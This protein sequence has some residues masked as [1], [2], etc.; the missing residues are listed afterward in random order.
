MNARM[1]LLLLAGGLSLGYPFSAGP[2][3]R[4]EAPSPPPSLETAKDLPPSSEAHAPA[5]SCP[6]PKNRVAELDAAFLFWWSKSTPTVPFATT[7]API[8]AGVLGAPTTAVVLGGGGGLDYNTQ[9]GA[10]FAGRFLVNEG[11][12]AAVGGFF[13]DNKDRERGALGLSTLAVPF[14]DATTGANASI[15]LAD[16]NAS[17]GAAT[18]RITNL[19][20]GLDASGFAR[21][22]MA[23]GI[24]LDVLAGFRFLQ[25]SESLELRT[26]TTVAAPGFFAGTPAPANSTYLGRDQFGTRNSFYGGQVGARASGSWGCITAQATASVALGTIRQTVSIA[27]DTILIAPGQGPAVVTGNVFTQ[28]TNVGA[29]RRD[30]FGVIPQIGFAVGY[31]AFDFA[32]VTLG[33][34]FLYWNNVARPGNQID[35]QVNPTLPPILDVGMRAG[36]A[37]PAP[38]FNDSDYW[39]QGFTVGLELA[40]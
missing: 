1:A 18:L 10:R 33:Y 27:G 2:L 20:W 17:V 40:F 9:V 4:G 28:T 7:S 13:V 38:M 39:A 30:R 32:R 22:E 26:T 3:V 16:P 23:Q 36:P 12:G 31:Q 14:V 37:R 19:L 11:F 15:L 29:Y 35:R 8:D 24:H 5:A 25:L 6:A 21:T 34:D